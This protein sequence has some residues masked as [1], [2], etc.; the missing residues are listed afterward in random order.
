MTNTRT[1]HF[2]DTNNLIPGKAFSMIIAVTVP[3]GGTSKTTTSMNIAE[4]FGR[5]GYDVTVHDADPQG[6]ASDW[7]N[8]SQDYNSELE[9]GEDN[10]EYE[11]W[12]F[13]VKS[14]NA[15]SIKR[16]VND[17]NV[18]II[19]T[20]GDPVMVQAAVKKADFTILPI[21]PNEIEVDR[22]ISTLEDLR[23]KKDSY[24]V[25]ITRARAS[26]RSLESTR[27]ELDSREIPRFRGYIP[28]RESI[29]RMYAHSPAIF[30]SLN[31]YEFAAGEIMDQFGLER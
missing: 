13:V 30:S 11:P 22:M 14:A 2:S 29:Q 5:A 10:P 9:D 15:S 16:L 6:T 7:Y 31:G 25:L 8:L 23:L 1:L 21:G 28:L 19:D 24:K 27:E 17:D 4:V 20:S 26:A 3:K 12:N 18:H